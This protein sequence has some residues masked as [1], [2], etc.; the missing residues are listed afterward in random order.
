MVNKTDHL[1]VTT[2]AA[3]NEQKKDQ[4]CRCLPQSTKDCWR[5]PSAKA[6]MV[7]KSM[8]QQDRD[9]ED[10]RVVVGDPAF[11][12][13]QADTENDGRDTCK[14]KNL[15]KGSRISATR[16]MTRAMDCK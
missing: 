2:R 12:H 15:R 14:K 11:G 5:G 7:D 6:V 3:K 16:L 1:G 10:A 4:E 13:V 8:C 9:N